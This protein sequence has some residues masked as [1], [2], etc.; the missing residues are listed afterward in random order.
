[1]AVRL[2]ITRFGDFVNGYV[3]AGYAVVVGVLG[4]YGAWLMVRGAKLKGALVPV[5][6]E[7]ERSQNPEV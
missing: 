6:V 5:K 7:E 4:A 1:M 2:W 3:E